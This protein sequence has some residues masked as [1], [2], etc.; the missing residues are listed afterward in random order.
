MPD[1]K[2]FT[3]SWR[4]FSWWGRE[5]VASSSAYKGRQYLSNDFLQPIATQITH[6]ARPKIID[7]PLTLISRMGQGVCL[8]IFEL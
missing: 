4:S 2:W 1:H 8:S 6:D 7:T 5:R 3:L